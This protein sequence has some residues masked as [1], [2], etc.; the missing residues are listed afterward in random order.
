MNNYKIISDFGCD[1][2]ETLLTQ[3]GIEVIPTNL[4]IEGEPDALS[5]ELD[6][7]EFYQKLR[8]KKMIK[9]SAINMQTFK[10]RF[11]EQLL[12]G[13]DVLYI[14]MSAGLSATFTSAKLAA[15]E[16]MEAYPERKIYCADSR[17][18]S[19]GVGLAAY[20]AA[21]KR[22]EGADLEETFAYMQNICSKL[23]SWFTVDDL[24]FL[25]RGGRLRTA[26]AVVGS[27]FMI[28]PILT[29]NEEGGLFAWGK[30]RGK[31]GAMEELIRRTE[32]LAF[33]P[34]NSIITISHADSMEEAVNLEMMLRAKWDVKDI[35]ITD[36]GPAFGAHCGPGGLAVF[37]VGKDPEEEN[38]ETEE[39]P[40][41][42]ETNNTAEAAEINE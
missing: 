4:H 6:I 22:E 14:G 31:K 13:F 39:I 21:L 41:P 17:S 3:Y 25:K 28:K 24:F 32:E 16:L 42:E 11:E 7:S 35:I 12:A 5:D 18:G 23:N 20:L 34:E 30:A 36:I 19:G 38:N 37:F 26:T 2:P 1:L 29:V 15:E 27:I 9:T 33:D 40:T 10:N 8:E